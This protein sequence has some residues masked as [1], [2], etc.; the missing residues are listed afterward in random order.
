M[1]AQRLP[2]VTVLPA[3]SLH[4]AERLTPDPFS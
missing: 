1:A 2:H 4:D 3:A